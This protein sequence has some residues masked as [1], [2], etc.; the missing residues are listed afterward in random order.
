MIAIT[1]VVLA[2]V[3]LSIVF[4]MLL[5]RRLREKYAA[6]WI[7]ISLAMLV[8]GTF[9]QLLLNLTS[10]FGVVLPANLLF[11]MAILLLLGVTLHLSWEQSQA[12]DEI[13]RAAEEIAILRADHEE[14]GLRVRRLEERDVR[15]DGAAGSH[16]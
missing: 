6:L 15:Q 11:A 1:G 12:E 9:P 16:D 8:I 3:M 4:A 2:L 7:V 5:T 10:F 14:L 13:R